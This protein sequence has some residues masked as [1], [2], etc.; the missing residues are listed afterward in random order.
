MIYEIFRIIYNFYFN[1]FIFYNL[2]LNKES[3]FAKLDLFCSN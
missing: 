3:K 2:I 1:I